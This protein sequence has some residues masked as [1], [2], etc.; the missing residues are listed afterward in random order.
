MAQRGGARPGAGQPKGTRQPHT[1]EAA[2]A[3]ARIIAL[4]SARVDDLFAEL[5]RQALPAEG[6]GDIVAIKELLDRAYG[7]PSQ[8]ITGDKDNPIEFYFNEQQLATIFS[9]R[10]TSGNTGSTN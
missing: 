4:V 8:A 9:R 10:N 6:K 5:L 3:K 1:L 2:A 7:K